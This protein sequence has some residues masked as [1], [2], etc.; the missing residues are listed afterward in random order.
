MYS[1]KNWE[2]TQ[3]KTEQSHSSTMGQAQV[4]L[5]NTSLDPNCVG[6]RYWYVFFIS[7][8]LTFFGGIFV[9]FVW[10]LLSYLCYGNLI[11]RFRKAVSYPSLLASPIYLCFTLLTKPLEI[12]ICQL[13]Y[14]PPQSFSLF[15]S[16]V[17]NI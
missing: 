13:C 1:M 17:L 3:K 2:C 6:Q 9:I 8:L 11:R 7:S 12:P 16:S 4:H 14:Y 5:D 15:R 10:R